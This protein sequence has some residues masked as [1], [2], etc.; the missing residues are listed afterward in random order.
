[1]PRQPSRSRREGLRPVR[2]WVPDFDARSFREEAHRQ[3][4]AVASSPGEKEDRDFIDAISGA[5]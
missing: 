2:I 4:L 5:E 3:S 1:M